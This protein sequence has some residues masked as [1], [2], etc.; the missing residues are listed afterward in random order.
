MYADCPECRKLWLDYCG[1]L[2]EQARL[3]KTAVVGSNEDLERSRSL[4]DDLL[5]AM[6]EHDLTAHGP[7]LAAGAPA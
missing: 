4:C 5:Q 3:K 7:T 2:R 6:R 1:A